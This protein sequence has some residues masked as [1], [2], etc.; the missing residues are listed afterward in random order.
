M[1]HD[2]TQR[3]ELRRCEAAEKNSQTSDRRNQ[4]GERSAKLRR[5]G[6]AQNRRLPNVQEPFS[7]R[8]P[9]EKS[10]TLIDHLCE[11]YCVYCKT[12]ASES[13]SNKCVK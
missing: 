3:Y 2:A 8:M 4:I 9:E 1:H 11:D 13:I 6:T 5:A 7:A 10:R 12:L